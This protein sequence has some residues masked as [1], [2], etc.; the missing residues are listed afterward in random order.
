[1]HR[2]YVNLSREQF[3]SRRKNFE[4]H[5]EAMLSDFRTRRIISRC[6]AGPN[7]ALTAGKLKV[8]KRTWTQAEAEYERSRYEKRKLVE[9]QAQIQVMRDLFMHV[10]AL[11][12]GTSISI[13]LSDMVWFKEKR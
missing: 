2:I 7:V 4:S 5:A 13:A 8:S 10:D 3:L 9:F 12:Y 11:P 1:M 6:K